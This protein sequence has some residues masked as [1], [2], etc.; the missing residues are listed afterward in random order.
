MDLD[1]I[2]KTWSEHNTTPVLCEDK[3]HNI[4][5]QR[6]KTALD[7]LISF[8]VFGCLLL[9]PLLFVPY[10]HAQVFPKMPY[11]V[12]TKYFY[13]ISCIIGFFWQL[14]KY[15]LLRSINISHASIVSCSKNISKYRLY[16][17]IE[18]IL[19]TLL[20]FVFIFSFAYSYID[21]L[22]DEEQKLK[23]YIFN[24]ILFV[25]VCIILLFYYKL[26]YYKRIKHIEASLKEVREMD[27][28]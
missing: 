19:G 21:I 10:L 1:N 12:F 14:Y 2:K 23:F 3:I 11:P 6:A 5:N 15:R 13:I 18:A 7:R 16:I 8:E 24:I 28:K 26:V 27:E 4:I 20:V 17:S 9:L 25:V 22:S